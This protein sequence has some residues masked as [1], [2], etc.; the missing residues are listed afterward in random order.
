M[1][2]SIVERNQAEARYEDSQAKGDTAIL[3]TL[4]PVDTNF[5]ASSMIRIRLGNM[6]A[7]STAY[8]RAY[9]YQKLEL[10]DMSYCFRLPMA[11]VPAYMGNASID[12]MSGSTSSCGVPQ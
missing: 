9:C 7:R 12:L 5:R 4:P 6:P 2:T 8:L 1:E 10:E 3:A 11:Y